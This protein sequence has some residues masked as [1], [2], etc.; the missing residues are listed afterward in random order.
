M[1]TSK[2]TRKFERLLFKG[3]P[4]QPEHNWERNENSNVAARVTGRPPSPFVGNSSRNCEGELVGYFLYNN[5]KQTEEFI[6]EI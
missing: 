5:E 4:E 1:T 3:I 6:S 2:I